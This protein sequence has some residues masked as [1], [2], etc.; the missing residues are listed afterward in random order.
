MF[1][2]LPVNTEVKEKWNVR[3]IGNEEKRDRDRDIN[4]LKRDKVQW[5]VRMT[6]IMRKIKIEKV[7]YIV[8]RWEYYTRR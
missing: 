4:I 5:E 7:T 6:Y 3:C 2:T 8:E 1:A